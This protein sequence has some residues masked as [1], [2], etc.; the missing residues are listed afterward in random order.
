MKAVIAGLVFD[1]QDNKNGSGQS[2]GQTCDIDDIKR[3]VLIEV[4]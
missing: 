4:A 1:I 3:F 2:H